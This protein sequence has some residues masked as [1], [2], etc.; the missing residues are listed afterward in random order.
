MLYMTRTLLLTGLMAGVALCSQAEENMVY[1]TAEFGEV[2]GISDNG[3]YVAIT[4]MDNHIAAD[5]AY[6]LDF[7]NGRFPA[8]VTVENLNAAKPDNTGYKRGWTDRGWN[9]DQFGDRGYAGICP[10][11]YKEDLSCESAITLPAQAIT[12]GDIVRWEARAVYAPFAESYRIE[13]REEGTDTWSVIGEYTAGAKWKTHVLPLD[14]Y[15]GR[16]VAVRV[17]CTSRGGYM[18]ALSEIAVGAPDE[19]RLV[20]ENGTRRYFGAEAAER[21]AADVEISVFNAGATLAAGSIVCLSDGEETSSIDITEPW[22]TGE[23]RSFTLEAAAQ[24]N[25]KTAYSVVYRPAVGDD[26]ALAKGNLFTSHFERNIFVDKATGMWCT[27]C[28]AGMMEME[29]LEREFGRNLIGVETHTAATS[30][31]ILE[32]PTYYSNIQNYSVPMFMLDRIRPSRSDNTSSFGKYYDREV[33]FR[34]GIESIS[35]DGNDSLTVTADVESAADIDNSADRYRIGYVLTAD[36]H[37]Q[38]TKLYYQQNA[39]N[40]PRYEQFYFLPSRITSNLIWFH[41]V[42]LTSQDAFTGI[43]G[44][45]PASLEAGKSYSYTWSIDRPQLLDDIKNGRVNVYVLDKQTGY[46]ENAFAARPGEVAAIGE[47]TDS[48]AAAPQGIYTLQ[49]I[50]LDRSLDELPAGFY[51]VNGKVVVKK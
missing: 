1:N 27:N 37:E 35:V 39:C 49:G 43:E 41:N 12:E 47:I 38:D 7:A 48:E 18:L 6:T 5:A 23:E 28:T 31:D 9:I 17:V 32:N 44:S 51:V 4:D 19:I 34:I 2:N 42:S 16:N 8:D 50:R 36:F 14:S 10:T 15:A 30:V 46:V 29:N 25:V 3:R 40:L 26:V 11:L 13:A 24:M 22:L 45:I 20:A 33:N 21:G